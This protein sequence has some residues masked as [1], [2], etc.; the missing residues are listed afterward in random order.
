MDGIVLAAVKGEMQQLLGC[1]I[2]KIYQP[3]KRDIVVHCRRPGSNLAVILSAD[4][5]NARV[6]LTEDVPENPLSPPSFCMLLRKYLEGGKITAVEQPDLERILEIKV[7]N[8][9]D[10]SELTTYRL[11]AEIMGRHSNIILVDAAGEVLDAVMR[12]DSR[13]NRY[14][15]IIPGA[16]YIP[17]PDQG[18]LSLLTLDWQPFLT[19]LAPASPEARLARLIQ[20]NFTGVSPKVAAELVQRAGLDPDS[21]RRDVDQDRLRDLYQVLQKLGE[22][23]KGGHFTPQIGLN[24]D[25]E[26]CGVSAIP[27]TSQFK[28]TREFASMSRAL[29]TYYAHKLARHEMAGL[30][31][32]LIEVVDRHLNRLAKK[33]KSQEAELSEA[34]DADKYRIYGE[35]LTANL[36]QLQ[37]GM[38]AVTLENFYDPDLGKITIPLDLR[39]TPSENAQAY[40]RRYNKAKKTLVEGMYHYQRSLE[41]QRYLEQVRTSLD[42]AVDLSDLLDIQRELTEEGYIRPVKSR[43]SKDP[44]QGRPQPLRFRSSD[45]LEILVGRNN[46]QNEYVTFRAAGPD[47]IWLHVKDIPGSHV[48]IKAQGIEPPASTLEEAALLAA[49]YSK[50]RTGRNVAVDYTARRHVRKPRGAKPGMVIYDHYRTIFVSPVPEVVRPLLVRQINAAVRDE[51]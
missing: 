4:P 28:A 33:I 51:T 26:P 22:K 32:N 24:T 44:R 35:L 10:S 46:R 49:Y 11:I 21:L 14:R 38:E 3:A 19:R 13:I 25:G 39:L 34:E 17:P 41:E 42:L 9:A 1:R 2:T 43:K 20:D 6:F 45:G 50:G 16:L 30:Q 15:E 5:Q 27:L 40:F 47:D 12:V 23:I 29:E 37:K 7:E 31:R 36:Y 8:F 18:K 48:I